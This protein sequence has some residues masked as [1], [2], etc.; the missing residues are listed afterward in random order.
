M[1]EITISLE[2]VEAYIK[3]LSGEYDEWW[4]PEYDLYGGGLVAFFRNVDTKFGDAADALLT[5]HAIE[6][7]RLEEERQDEVNKYNSM[8][9]A[10]SI[11]Q[12]EAT[13]TSGLKYDTRGIPIGEAPIK[14]EGE[15]CIL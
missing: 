15:R 4:S 6:A 13:R 3:T 5:A 10:E 1:S 7:D 9:V 8:S 11:A 2:Q 14:I 12:L